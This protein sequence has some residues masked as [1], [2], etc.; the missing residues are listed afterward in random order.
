MLLNQPK[1]AGTNKKKDVTTPRLSVACKCSF[2]NF[3]LHLQEV[4]DLKEEA[5]ICETG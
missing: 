5:N 2:F 1:S 4:I 3:G